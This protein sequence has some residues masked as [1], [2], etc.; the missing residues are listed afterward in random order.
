M[1]AGAFV[2]ARSQLLRTVAHSTCE[3]EYM[4]LC[5]GTKQAVWWRQLH[6]DIGEEQSGP[7]VILED[8]EGA[9][10]LSYNPVIHERSKHIDVAYHFTRERVESGEINIIHCPTDDMWAD[11]LTKALPKDKHVKFTKLLLGIA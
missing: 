7:T 4:T 6:K 1:K 2:S 5:D 10:A 3:A 8:N 9:I 11:V